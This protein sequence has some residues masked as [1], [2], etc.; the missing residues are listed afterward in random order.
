MSIAQD[1]LEQRWRVFVSL[2]EDLVPLELEERAYAR[3]QRGRFA[4][5]GSFAPLS[6][7][8]EAACADFEKTWGSA[9]FECVEA[10]DANGTTVFHRESGSHQG[11]YDA[12]GVDLT[13]VPDGAWAGTVMIHNHPRG[14]AYPASDPR[15]S[16]NS[17]SGDDVKTGI[18][19]GASE[20]RV[21]GPGFKYRLAP[22]EGQ[23]WPASR[24]VGNAYDRI[25]ADIRVEFYRRIDN[26]YPGWGGTREER[27]AHADAEHYDRLWTQVSQELGL[28]YERSASS[29]PPGG[30]PYQSTMHELDAAAFRAMSGAGGTS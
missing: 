9:G 5:T 24:E 25:N 18:D 12:Y 14:L 4:H 13:D 1:V 2:P 28:R 7:E 17:F 10:I 26:G 8:V 19:M 3:D 11:G 20:L 22:A 15:S 29:I 23:S 21:V 27:A 30:K 6:P 16:A